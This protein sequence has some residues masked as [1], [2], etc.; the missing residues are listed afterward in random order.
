MVKNIKDEVNSSKENQIYTISTVGTK[1]NTKKGETPMNMKEDINYEVNLVRINNKNKGNKMNIFA[2][3]T[4]E[5]REME[6]IK[7]EVKKRLK[8]DHIIFVDTP[9][10]IFIDMTFRYHIVFSENS[11]GYKIYTDSGFELGCSS[12]NFMAKNDM[13][14]ALNWTILEINL[15]LHGNLPFNVYAVNDGEVA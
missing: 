8:D 9:F 12:H 4:K 7:L 14:E 10:G 11:V 15:D 3:K 13:F 2:Q 1:D 5:E 6:I